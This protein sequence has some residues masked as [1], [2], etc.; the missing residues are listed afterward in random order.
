V[1]EHIVGEGS[2]VDDRIAPVVH[3]DAFRKE[4]A[5]HA[6]RL[7]LDRV[8]AQANSHHQ[9]DSVVGMGSSGRCPENLHEPFLR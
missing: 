6:V 5:A 1:L 3:A 2:R 9:P 7:A 8:D 4:L